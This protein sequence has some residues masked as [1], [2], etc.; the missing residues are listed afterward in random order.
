M[1]VS[2]PDEEKGTPELGDNHNTTEQ[3]AEEARV[4]DFYYSILPRLEA[5]ES[6]RVG[7]EHA[8]R[9]HR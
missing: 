2:L 8:G 4:S 6:P 9:C 1:S 7:W 3:S 5:T